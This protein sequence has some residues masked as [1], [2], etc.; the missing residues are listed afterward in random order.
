MKDDRVYLRHILEAVTRVEEYTANGPEAFLGST[1]HQDAVLRNLQTLAEAS[2]R[3]SDALKLQHPEV[4]WKALSAFR[5]VLVHDYLGVD[6]SLVYRSV[7][8]D[9]P[10][11]KLAVQKL[12]TQLGS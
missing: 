8:S 1:L 2:Q 7:T 12:L 3:V 11:L 4:D 9:L 5:N 6:L 10:I